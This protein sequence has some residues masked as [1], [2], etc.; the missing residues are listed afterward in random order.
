MSLHVRLKEDIYDFEG[1][2]KALVLNSDIFMWSPSVP[3]CVTHI[4]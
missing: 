4:H 2:F 1:K 3:K